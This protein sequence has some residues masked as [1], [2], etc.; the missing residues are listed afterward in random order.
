MLDRL[1]TAF[2]QLADQHGVTKIETIGDA[3][4]CATNLRGDQVLHSHIINNLS[5]VTLPVCSALSVHISTLFAQ[6][7]I[8][9]PYFL[10]SFGSVSARS[11]S[12]FLFSLL[13]HIYF[14]QDY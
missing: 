6:S 13:L 5:M 14:T 3:Y 4:L 8:L 11:G 1:Y 12:T 2:D 10:Y 7:S 9:L